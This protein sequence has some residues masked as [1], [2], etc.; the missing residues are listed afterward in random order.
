[1][2]SL[3][4]M[5][6]VAALTTLSGCT[7]HNEVKSE[8]TREAT[9]STKLL[10]DSRANRSD[11]FYEE[12]DGLWLGGE[13]KALPKQTKDLPA[14]RTMVTLKKQFPLTL[15]QI[16][17]F[18][19]TEVGLQVQVAQDA[20]AHAKDS[21][22]QDTTAVVSGQAGTPGGFV[23]QYEGT[24][25]GLLELAT[26]RTGTSW[27]TTDNGVAIFLRKTQSFA[28]NALPGSTTLNTKVTNTSGGSSGGG[29]GGQ[30]GG[31]SGGGSKSESGQTTSMD[32]DVKLFDSIA[33]S[34]KN[35]LAQ[36]DQVAASPAASTITVTASPVVLER[37]EHFIRDINSRLKRQVAFDM[38]V[39]SVDLTHGE[40]FGLDW[41]AVYNNVAKG[42]GITT[43]SLSNAPTDANS[44]AVNVLDPSS[45][46]YG[47][48]VVINALKSQGHVDVV[49]TASQ[50]TLSGQPTPVQVA[51]NT[52]YVQRA[53]T[54]LVAN[55]GAQTTF[56]VGNVTTGFAAT[57][58]P[59]VTD[60]D[61][62]L[63]QLQ[64]QLSSLRN[65]RQIGVSAT[66][67][68]AGQ[69]T[70]IEAPE[71]DSRDFLQ[72]VRMKSGQTLVLSGFEQS[73][74]KSDARGIGS[75]EFQLAGGG[76]NSEKTRTV[77]V[78]LLTAKIVN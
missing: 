66:P 54:T 61:E 46:F 13:A 12:I 48:E 34:V 45:R 19:T 42:Y 41:S 22:T 43:S 17:S 60:E 40:N 63:L 7:L 72:R 77:I 29:G 31:A 33:E 36:G 56:E 38:R 57:V 9:E 11:P 16:A 21:V 73:K 1:M 52:A 71:V 50:I 6:I 49:T 55:A 28:V 24:T 37:V 32:V 23:V 2:R 64:L 18:I 35:M 27:E 3:S 74:L 20:V 69:S 62:I 8:A 75:A 68:A 70:Q 14:L 78:V 39:V 5:L 67:G 15:T 76:Q 53:E 58:L 51:N 47:S 10:A 59:V 4:L 26:A 44:L 25:R 30:G 65:L